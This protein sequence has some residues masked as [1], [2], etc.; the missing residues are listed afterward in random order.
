M[1]RIG[2]EAWLTS[3]E[4]VVLRMKPTESRKRTNNT[5]LQILK[6][7]SVASVALAA[8]IRHIVGRAGGT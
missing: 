4:Y 5:S 2:S 6:Q 8:D 1:F 3:N 7:S